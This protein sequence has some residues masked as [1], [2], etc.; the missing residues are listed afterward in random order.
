M[1]NPTVIALVAILAASAASAADPKVPSGAAVAQPVPP[2]VCQ[3]SEEP[4]PTG[5]T[6]RCRD[7]VFIFSRDR[8]KACSSH[9][10]VAERCG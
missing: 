1:R 7:G 6:A 3:T 2:P 4:A 8:R 9:G 5:A 10:G